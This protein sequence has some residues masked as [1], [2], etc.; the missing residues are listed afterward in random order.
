MEPINFKGANVVYGKDQPEYLPLPAKKR[1]ARGEVITCWQLSPEELK[2]VQ[3][4]GVIWCSILTFNQPLQ[5][6]LLATE[7]LDTT[8]L[9][10]AIL[11][12][13]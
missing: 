6:I 1:D 13:K 9:G 10:D 4:T 11:N 8:E 5:P 2:K 3:E 12:E 7:I